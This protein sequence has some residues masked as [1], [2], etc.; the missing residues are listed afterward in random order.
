M[1]LNN[2]SPWS[3]SVPDWLRQRYRSRVQFPEGLYAPLVQL[4]ETRDLKSLQY[5]SESHKEHNKKI[6][7]A[8]WI[9]Q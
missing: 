1:S 9:E 5:E 2:G 6:P 3:D 7:L 4:A 8:Q